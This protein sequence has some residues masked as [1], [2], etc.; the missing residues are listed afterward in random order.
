MSYIAGKEAVVKGI[1]QSYP[2]ETAESGMFR[3]T[4]YIKSAVDSK[5]GEQLK[6]LDGQDIFLLSHQEF[7]TGT[8]Y[9]IVIK[10]LSDRTRLNPGS[11]MNKEIH[12]KLI[13][14]N[15]AEQKKISCWLKSKTHFAVE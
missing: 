6:D 15:S 2:T 9:E 12:A 13:E 10:F 3:Q 14:V 5:T 11:F 4:I 7:Q 8:E 1:V